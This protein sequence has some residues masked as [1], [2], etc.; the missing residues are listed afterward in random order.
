M[1]HNK[2]TRTH[3]GHHARIQQTICTHTHTWMCPMCPTKVVGKKQQL[4]LHMGRFHQREATSVGPNGSSKSR[5]VVTVPSMKLGAK[6]RRQDHDLVHGARNRKQRILKKSEWNRRQLEGVVLE[7]HGK[8]IDAPAHYISWSAA[9]IWLDVQLTPSW[10]LL[11]GGRA[12]VRAHGRHHQFTRW[13]NNELRLEGR[14]P[15]SPQVWINRLLR[16]CIS[17][18]VIITLP[19]T[20]LNLRVLPKQKPRAGKTLHS[21]R[22]RRGIHCYLQGPQKMKGTSIFCKVI[23]KHQSKPTVINARVR[24]IVSVRQR[25]PEFA[26][27]RRN[28]PELTVFMSTGHKAVALQTTL[29]TELREHCKIPDNTGNSQRN[30]LTENR[31]GQERL[32]RDFRNCR[33]H[34]KRER[35]Q[36]FKTFVKDEVTKDLLET[37]WRQG[38]T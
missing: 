19:S 35:P 12:K 32:E 23:H 30:G 17:R 27:V 5:N 38:K 9:K 20:P 4:I 36:K 21:S 10:V 29:K 2:D 8:T 7:F 25:S 37:C 24:Q 26:K 14:R 18:F 11:R 3:Q 22:S 15:G 34:S 28:S 16:R 13:Q 33:K 6:Y 31:V 1:L